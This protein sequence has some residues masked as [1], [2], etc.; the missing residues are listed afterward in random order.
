MTMHRNRNSK[1]L[2]DMLTVSKWLRMN[3][4]RERI[5][6]TLPRGVV[7]SLMFVATVQAAPSSPVKPQT[8]PAF[9][10]VGIDSSAVV[11][12]ASAQT[13]GGRHLIRGYVLRKAANKAV[14]TG[15]IDLEIF[16]PSGESLGVGQTALTPTPL[17][18]GRHGRSYFRWPVPVPVPPG[19]RIQ[20]RYHTG[21]HRSSMSGTTDS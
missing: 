15:H 10:L 21:S 13:D 16:S 18:R 6:M 20:F 8:E 12:H 4:R 19:G 2:S 17:P 9:A 7:V 14:G 11:I 1:L 5:V 3:Y